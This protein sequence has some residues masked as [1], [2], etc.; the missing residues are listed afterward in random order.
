L[1]VI[2]QNKYGLPEDG[3][4]EEKKKYRNLENFV[5][6]IYKKLNTKSPLFV[7]RTC[8]YCGEGDS[9][10]VKCSNAKLSDSETG[11]CDRGFM[12][13]RCYAH[14][15]QGCRILEKNPKHHEARRIFRL[16]NEDSL[17]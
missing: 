7:S 9:H 10:T 2:K 17:E 3:N 14:Y 16:N 4:N 13:G 6:L 11:S 8:S 12:C 15:E 1:E 5:D